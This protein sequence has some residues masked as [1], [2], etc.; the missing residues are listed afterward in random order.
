MYQEGN[1]EIGLRFRKKTKQLLKPARSLK[2]TTLSSS[3]FLINIIK[4]TMLK[5]EQLI[6]NYSTSD[7]IIF[8]YMKI[9]S[10]SVLNNNI[11]ME[12]DLKLFYLFCKGD[13][14][15]CMHHVAVERTVLV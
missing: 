14:Y 12:Y 2:M 6:R 3:F 1:R 4:F 13:R 7:M 15:A 11:I 8:L 5:R 9:V 10:T